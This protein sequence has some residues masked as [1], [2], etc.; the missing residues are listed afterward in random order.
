MQLRYLT[1]VQKKSQIEKDI[2][3]ELVTVKKQKEKLPEL[4]PI[5][6]LDKYQFGKL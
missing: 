5:S 3:L 1:I 2:K 6:S 4:E